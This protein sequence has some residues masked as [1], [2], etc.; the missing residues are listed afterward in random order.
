MTTVLDRFRLDG[1]V[2]IVTGASAGLGVAIAQALAEAGADVALGARRADKLQSTKALVEG[3]GRRA[4]AVSTDISDPDAC[5]RLVDAAVGGLGR[6]D[7]LVNNA[8]I[9]TARPALKETPEEFRAVTDVN[10]HGTFWMAQAA[11]RAM[12]QGG[13][14]V[15]ITS[16]MAFLSVGMPQASYM[17]SKAAIIGMTRDLAQQWTSRRGIRVN[18]VA[19][20]IF[21]TEMTG[22]F[23]DELLEAQLPRV[24]MGRAGDPAELAAAVVFLAGDA[25]SYITGATIVVDGGRTIL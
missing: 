10:V 12:E 16:I 1:K 3:A 4:I 7:I 23:F 9:G 17:A 5:Q 15:N 6:L 22:H 2:A 13:S 8:G 20:G 14:I 18:A 19:P 11:A 21:E 24:P 25:A